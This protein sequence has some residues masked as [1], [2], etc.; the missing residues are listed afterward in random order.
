MLNYEK[1]S[2]LD[3]IEKFLKL[4]NL[5]RCR[6][7]PLPGELLAVVACQMISVSA[8]PIELEQ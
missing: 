5:Q 4:P 2:P 6:V 1:S 3:Y 7:E 8:I